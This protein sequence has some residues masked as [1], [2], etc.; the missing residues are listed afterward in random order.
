MLVVIAL[1]CV[2]KDATHHKARV[3]GFNYSHPGAVILIRV[4]SARTRRWNPSR[5]NRKQT[6]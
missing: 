4:L 5:K 2:A 3:E 1:V 6:Q